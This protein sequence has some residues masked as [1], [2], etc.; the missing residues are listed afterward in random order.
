MTFW[1]FV[2][3][4]AA[5][6]AKQKCFL[7]IL[8][9]FYF[10]CC[11]PSHETRQKN[12]E[13]SEINAQQ[14]EHVLRWQSGWG[15]MPL[16]EMESDRL[17]TT[18]SSQRLHL[19]FCSLSLA[20]SPPIPLSLIKKSNCMVIIFS[21]LLPSRLRQWDSLDVWLAELPAGV[22]FPLSFTKV[23]GG[24]DATGFMESCLHAHMHTCMCTCGST[25]D[26]N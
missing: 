15:M 12:L 6:F 7:L 13:M 14:M 8:F 19:P 1:V 26:A 16:L 4:A 22:M 23:H 9:L 17:Q 10:S 25:G 2:F 20:L 5:R 21:D 18:K 3:I 11:L 24:G